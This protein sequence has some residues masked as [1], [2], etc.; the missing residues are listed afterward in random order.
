ME[1]DRW[2]PGAA[3]RRGGRE[4]DFQQKKFL[5][6]LRVD[7]TEKKEHLYTPG[8]SMWLEIGQADWVT[9]AYVYAYLVGSSGRRR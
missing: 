1:F 7:T 2:P 4:K 8:A 9:K 6:A 3:E 5:R